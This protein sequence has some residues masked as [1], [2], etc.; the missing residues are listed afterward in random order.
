MASVAHEFVYDVFLSF[1]GEDTRYGFT[2]NLWKALNDNGVRT[3][4]DDD[5]LRKGDEITPSLLQAIDDSKIA[6]VVLSKNYATSSFC[7]QELSKI[8]DS[9]KDKADRSI[10]PVFY[11]VDP[12]DVRKLKRSY[13]EA[14]VKHDEASSSSSHDLDK[15]KMSLQQVADMSGF[16]Y[17]GYVPYDLLWF[18]IGV[19]DEFSKKAVF[20]TTWQH[21]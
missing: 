7:L 21:R 16:H 19:I 8:I 12:S 2:G 10:L 15:W 9:M 18:F 4:M 5:E 14:M 17:K 1:R 6:I 11:M 20:C 13:G 3:F